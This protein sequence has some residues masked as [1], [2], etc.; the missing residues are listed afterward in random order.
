MQLKVC[1][2]CKQEKSVEDF[3]WFNKF[4]GYRYSK[5]KECHKA[6]VQAN[7]YVERRRPTHAERKA[8][9][10]FNGIKSR[11]KDTDLTYEWLLEKIQIGV[12]EVTGLP[13]RLGVQ[14]QGRNPYAPSVD[15]IDP[16]QGYTLD[17][18]QVVIWMYNAAKGNWS[19]ED[20]IE[21][22]K[23]LNSL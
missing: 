18:C 21:M 13:F 3:Y 14:G 17:N 10:I 4:K 16:R 2:S 6:H 15:R 12:C 8:R 20:V 5:C 22:A 7:Q 23:A 9:S 19:H 1:T 11:Y